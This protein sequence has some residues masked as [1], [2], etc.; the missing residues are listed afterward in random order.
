MKIFSA[1]FPY[2]LRLQ[3]KKNKNVETQLLNLP[4]TRQEQMLTSN[5]SNVKPRRKMRSKLQFLS[6][7]RELN[8]PGF[9][10]EKTARSNTC[11]SNTESQQLYLNDIYFNQHNSAEN[12]IFKGSCN[13]H[14][15]R[16]INF[17]P[18]YFFQPTFEN[19]VPTR[20][21]LQDY[22]KQQKEIQKQQWEQQQQKKSRSNEL[23]F[24]QKKNE[25]Y[26][27]KK[28][29][30]RPPTPKGNSTN[31]IYP[32][33]VLNKQISGIEMTSQFLETDLSLTPQKSDFELTESS[34]I[35]LTNSL[36]NVHNT[37]GQLPAIDSL[38]KY[39]VK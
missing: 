20:N 15:H 17:L 27:Q 1:N 18:N 11:F 4:K 19:V 7:S 10:E 3:E 30:N 35:Y 8:T 16:D 29:Q 26:L 39:I 12:R 32:S 24:P 23:S 33:S 14:H 37:N 2:S 21:T 9:V 25:T 28:I 22:Q 13:S 5:G 6:A 38:L 36:G 31:A 34:S